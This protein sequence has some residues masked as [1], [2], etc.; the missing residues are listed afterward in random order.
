[1]GRPPAHPS[2]VVAVPVGNFTAHQDSR[3]ADDQRDLAGRDG[4]AAARVSVS[5]PNSH[6][7]REIGR[8]AM[9]RHPSP[10]SVRHTR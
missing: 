3:R 2:I 4:H 10:K 9:C 8:Q 1:M 6:I 7:Q 5:L